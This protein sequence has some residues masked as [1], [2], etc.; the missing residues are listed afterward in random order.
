M[1]WTDSALILAGAIGAIVAVIHGI[2]MQRLMVRPLG[3]AMERDQMSRPL[4]ILVPALLQF[5]TFNWFVSGLAL[6]GTVLW[7][8]GEAKVLAALLAGSSYAYGALFN[9][10]GTKGRHP[11]WF[12]YAIA[13]GL[14]VYGLAA[15]PG[16]PGPGE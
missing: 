5:S 14:I 6:V 3:S 8:G 9:F 12:A 16:G 7:L 4:R 15:T 10:L 2:L 13:T 11:G 1:S